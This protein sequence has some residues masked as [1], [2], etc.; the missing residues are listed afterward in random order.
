M[1]LFTIHLFS[2]KFLCMIHLFSHFLWF[3]NFHKWLFFRSH[4][5]WLIFTWRIDYHVL[6]HDAFIFTWLFVLPIRYSRFACLALTHIRFFFCHISFYFPIWFFFMIHLYS[7]MICFPTWFIHFHIWFLSTW[8]IYRH[9]FVT[10]YS[11][12]RS[13]VKNTC[14]NVKCV[15]FF[16]P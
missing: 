16:P 9:K 8:C 13:H 3:V 7:H 6:L 10:Y 2:N 15:W 5:W 12:N 4:F 1:I 11:H 14:S